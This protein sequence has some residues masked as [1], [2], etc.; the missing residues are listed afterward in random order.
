MGN[1]NSSLRF[2]ECRA[3]ACGQ[4]TA[5]KDEPEQRF[6]TIDACLLAWSLNTDFAAQ[7]TVEQLKRFHAQISNNLRLFGAELLFDDAASGLIL[8]HPVA[9]G[10]M[11]AADSVVRMGQLLC[12]WAFSQ[13]PQ[14]LM[15]VGVDLGPFT[16]LQL[17]NSRNRV[18][19]FGGAVVGARR[20]AESSRKEFT[21]HMTSTLKDQLAALRFLPVVIATM[22]H[23]TFYLDA[24]TEVHDSDSAD[25]EAY[26]K[27]LSVVSLGQLHGVEGD[28]MSKMPFDSF[29]QLL[30]DHQVDLSKFGKGT[31]KTL[32]QFYE[33]VVRDEKCCLQAMDGKLHRSV[34]LVRI[35]LRFR[36]SQG[37]QRELRIKS[38]TTDG[39]TRIRNQPL[40]MVIC[41]GHKGTWQQAM[42]K[43]FSEK[44]ELNQQ[45]QKAVLSISREDYSYEENR[46]DSDT[47]PGILT[48]YKT[49]SIVVQIKDRHH[50]EL[51][52]MGLP[53]GNDF[54]T[55][56][57]GTYQWTWANVSN[58]Q[59]EEI[60][61]L[62]TKHG[63]DIAE[64][65][66][67]AF[68]DLCHEVHETRQST[69]QVIDGELVRCIQIVKVWVSAN[70]LNCKHYLII[71]N[72]EQ[73]GRI[74]LLNSVRT[75]SMRMGEGQTWQDA[76]TE[77]LYKKLGID[78]RLQRE[79]LMRSLSEFCVEVEYSQSYPGLKT[80]Y[81]I[82]EVSC[83]LV[84]PL[85]YRWQYI[86]LPGALDFTF[87]RQMTTLTG[88]ED[89]V[90]TRFGWMNSSDIENGF[91]VQGKN[92][93]L[94]DKTRSDM[95]SADR[96]WDVQDGQVSPPEPYKVNGADEL[97]IK[98][99]MEK[100]TTDWACARRAAEQIRNPDYTTKEFF[101]DVLKA[102]PELRLY[103]VV[104]TDEELSP[105]KTPST[106]MANF[107]SALSMRRVNMTS[108]NRT[109][110]DE[111]QRT[112][113]AL[114]TIFWLLRLHLDGKEC[115][116]FG[117]DADWKLRS[118]TDFEEDAMKEAEYAKR[119]AFLQK[120]DWR[121]IEKLFVAAGILKEGGGCDTDRV[122]A[123]LVLMAIHDIMK[124]D[125]LRPTV[126][127][128][129]EEF[130]GYRAG[131]QIS[132][133]DIALSYVLEMCP[134]ALPSFAGLREDL[135]QSIKF[136]HCK[137]DYN[138]GWLVQAEA[139]PGALFKNFKQVVMETISQDKKDDQACKD[140]A[141]YFVHWF[142][143][144]AGA[145]ACPKAGCEKFV[146][147]FPQPVLGSFIDS[148]SSV[149]HLGSKTET[150][151]F[152]DYLLWR[153][154]S[155]KPSLGEAPTGTGAMALMRMVVMA[156]GDSIAILRHFGKLNKADQ[157]VLSQELAMTGIAD[158]HFQRDSLRE[159]RGPAILVYYSPAL[160]QKAGKKDPLAALHMLAEVFRKARVLWPLRDSE[161][162]GNKTVIVRIDVI[163]D[164][165]TAGASL[166]ANEQFV[167]Q[168]LTG[169]DGHAKRMTSNEVSSADRAMIQPLVLGESDAQ[170][171]TCP[172]LRSGRSA[173]SSEQRT[174][175]LVSLFIPW[176]FH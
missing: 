75:L 106:A 164:D 42:E 142:A 112:I 126:A 77:V 80:M 176:R 113:G 124:L 67:H 13:S 120:T 61:N 166:K 157:Q 89:M 87:S 71:R 33:A 3:R 18:S 86:G 159:T 101:D 84:N 156:Q 34:E 153:W 85:D 70:V 74:N 144:L 171:L 141:F 26:P 2:D 114:F 63:I 146:L 28:R 175:G 59:E 10:G 163:K 49:H 17:P 12:R 25:R 92:L 19:Y 149:W 21:V 123:M 170:I 46:A 118:K 57:K 60:V 83:D 14:F 150:Q 148:F 30:R 58:S 102:F 109:G 172:S 52:K 47:V 111:F 98:R 127:T 20:L 132:D 31:A 23:K 104:K 8:G 165:D 133:H 5:D 6:G 68:A 51:E 107:G 39:V 143:D 169:K 94:F 55:E 15:Y 82:S 11:S 174:R 62:L 41:V 88:E 48:M 36:D 38:V 7:V 105:V 154:S 135:R 40:G 32:Q 29:C 16:A 122:L 24:F 79:A 56:R 65:T 147:K 125:I 168:K 43:C 96:F 22:H 173:A 158:Q 78:E 129:I 50:K 73:R 119:E 93:T 99:V 160:M 130:N 121:A 4:V 137:L 97:L 161:E 115:F 45:T 103:C 27:R 72:K 81:S 64:F 117:L 140:I 134:Q 91:D 138:M 145:E 37:R 128:D 90:I 167:L 95:S 162:D 116:C 139:P 100:T 69:L 131:E 9:E 76:C 152:E 1:D 35:R 44:L 151:V 53:E 66:W 110:D 54:S 155:H 136:T 108:G